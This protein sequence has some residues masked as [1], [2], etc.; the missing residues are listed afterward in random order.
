[1][2]DVLVVGGGRIGGFAAEMLVGMGFRVGVADPDEARLKAFSRRLGVEVYRGRAWD[3]VVLD[4]ARGSGVVAVALPG[5]VAFKAVRI[6]LGEGCRVVDAS[7]YPEDPWSLE[8]LASRSLY[9]PDAGL[10]PGLS[11]MLAARVDSVL[12]GAERIDILVGG[13]SRDPSALLG[14][15]AAWSAEDLVDEYV[16]PARMRVGGRVVSVDPLSYT[17]VAEIPGSGVFEYFASDG[18]RTLLRSLSHVAGLRELTLRYPGH[19]EAARLLRS[20]GLLDRREVVVVEGCRCPASL[21]LARLLEEKLPRSGDRVVL[22]VE[23]ARGEAER[24]FK[25]DMVGEPGR[26]AMSITTGGFLAAAAAA[27]LQGLVE[28]FTPPERLGAVGEAYTTIL[29]ILGKAGVRLEEKC[30]ARISAP[31]IG[32]E[33]TPDPAP[34]TGHTQLG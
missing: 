11:N 29:R 30:G 2:L 10:A 31:R 19:L 1:M 28:G 16:R 32:S 23:G 12:R 22:Y 20:L 25:L 13:L 21:V 8:P 15:T 7:F 5:R 6:L 18:L 17:G 24:C 9:V 3:R 26:T 4:A 34:T 27:A 14:L 33:A